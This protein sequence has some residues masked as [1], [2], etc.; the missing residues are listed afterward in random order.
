[1]NKPV[2]SKSDLFHELKDIA[3]QLLS[4]GDGLDGLDTEGYTLLGSLYQISQKSTQSDLSASEQLSSETAE[5]QD[6]SKSQ[7]QL[8]VLAKNL[9]DVFW[10]MDKDLNLTYVSPAIEHLTGYKPDEYVKIPIDKRLTE[11][12]LK[13]INAPEDMALLQ[14]IKDG[15]KLDVSTR[16]EL[17]QI[18]RDGSLVYTEVFTYPVYN[19]HEEFDYLFGITRNIT[20]QKK[21][22]QEISK[23]NEELEAKVADRTL[24]LTKTLEELATS[25]K[26]YRNLFQSM[27]SGVVVHHSDGSIQGVNSSALEILGLSR[28]QIEEMFSKDQH[29]QPNREYSSEYPN[30]K[31]PVFQVKRTCAEVRNHVMRVFNPLKQIFIYINVNAIPTFDRD[32]QLETIYV[33]FEDISERIRAERA[34]QESEERFS[35]AMKAANDGLFE[36]HVDTNEVYYSPRYKEMLGYSD[37]ELPS[38]SSTWERL[39]HPSDKERL[40]TVLE[41]YLEGRISRFEVEFRMEHKDGHWVDILSRAIGIKNPDGKYGRLIGTNVDI[42]QRKRAELQLQASEEKYRKLFDEAIDSIFVIDADSGIIV[43]CNQNACKMLER[44]RA[45]L[46]GMHQRD[47]HSNPGTEEGFSLDFKKHLASAGIVTDEQVITKS[48]EF[49]DVLIKS[50]IM[51]IDGRRLV[52]S[53]FRDV[54]DRKKAER[55]LRFIEGQKNRFFELSVDMLCIAGFD[56]YFKQLSAAWQET[57]GWSNA[58][59]LARPWL[60]FVHPDDVETTVEAGQRLLAGEEVVRFV[61]RYRCKDGKYRWISWNS[62]ALHEIELIYAAARD[63]T[64][65]KRAE[66]LIRENQQSLAEAQRIAQLGNWTWYIQE[67]RLDWSD[68]I[69]RIFGQERDTY[70]VSYDNLLQAVHPED[71]QIVID[72]VDKS[73]K[74]G[75]YE[76]QHRVLKPDGEVLHVIEQGEVTFDGQGRPEVMVGIVQDITDRVRAQQHITDLQEM[77]DKIFST[78]PMAMLVYRDDGSC[79]MVNDA[80]TG[81]IGARKDQMLAQNFKHIKSWQ[82]TGL[83]TLAEEAMRTFEPQEKEVYLITSFGKERW[84]DCKF[85]AFSLGDKPHLLLIIEDIS[86]RKQYEES[87]KTAIQFHKMHSS[88]EDLEAIISFGLEEAVRLSNSKIGYFHFVN[89]DQKTIALTAW[90]KETMRNCEVGERATHYPVDQAGIWVDCI[91]QRKAVIHNDY[92]SAEGRKGLPEGHTE[93]L[94]DMAIPLFEG[95]NIIAVLGVG[96]KENDY[97]QQNIEQ[98]LFVAEHM[99]NTVQRIRAEKA[100]SIMNQRYSLATRAAEL[101]IWDWDVKKDQLVWDDRMYQLYGASKQDGL[102]Y[103]AWARAVH[104]EDKLQTEKAVELALKEDKEF[105]IEFRVVHPDGSTHHLK[106]FADVLKG[107]DGDI[108]RMIGINMDISEQKRIENELI[109]MRDEAEQANRAKSEFLANMSHE[110]RTPLN[111]VIGFSELLTNLS[112]DKQIQKH[113]TSIKI[114]GRG[115]LTIIN[116]ILDLSKIEAGMMEI[117]FS[118]VNPYLI[119][120]EVKQLFE[121]RILEKGL[122]FYFEIDPSLPDTLMLDEIRLRQVLLNLVGNATKFTEN[123]YIK[124]TAGKTDSPDDS[125]RLDLVVAI[126]DSGVGIAESD[127]GLIFDSFRQQSGNITRKFEGTGLGLTIS[128]KLTEMMGGKITVSSNEGVGSVF[129]LTLKGVE[130]SSLQQPPGKDADFDMDSVRFEPA[131]V[132]VVDDVE[133]N[134]EML[135]ELLERVGL[136]MVEAEDGLQGI[137]KARLERPD[138]ILMDIRMPEMDGYEAAAHIKSFD[139][140]ADIPIIALTATT[141]KISTGEMQSA[142]LD[143]FLTKPVDVEELFGELAKHLGV[144]HVLNEREHNSSAGARLFFSTIAEQSDEVKSKLESETLQMLKKMKGVIKPS[145]VQEL[146]T[147]LEDLGRLAQEDSLITLAADIKEAMNQFD[148][149]RVK[150]AVEMILISLEKEEQ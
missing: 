70:A 67:D 129:T 85:N 31:H 77:S 28:E 38:E 44:P 33:V 57:L 59:L 2:R 97:D 96:N 17:E 140:T 7:Q 84:L 18:C 49:R 61:N 150:K 88:G 78:S 39:C 16:L 69:F 148:L 136:S 125:S 133:S 68:E 15:E 90:S 6:F 137:N 131:K 110:I 134:R 13:K 132:L 43:D 76:V 60:E 126:E 127:L 102:A 64:E 58:E 9:K 62:E 32:N 48:G 118:P 42:S 20:K 25:E 117:A 146:C 51:E 128:R 21:I 55:E 116:D 19:E 35:Y 65:A 124:L 86:E 87:L 29:R 142:G 92:K 73:L 52:Q 50:N 115:L 98:L 36:W 26:H 46:I 71:R 89:P 104:P 145:A 107:E 80:A 22:E 53:I 95:E 8:E 101:G 121:A 75:S 24:N 139:G 105:D 3:R 27:T 30:E 99:I 72:V 112:T 54:T 123:G 149:T 143:G 40:I 41:D 1:M 11:A 34:L 135:G 12:S 5:H 103:D 144:K 113:A 93:L 4:Y 100:L 37:E 81:I 66:D 83:L 141:Q 109:R 91:R 130:I 94:R 45:E 47:L 82:Q 108:E 79:V 106:G 56:G 63:I 23:L 147:H 119:F 14:R 114:A 122:D 10:T 74:E 138:V 120:S 111:A